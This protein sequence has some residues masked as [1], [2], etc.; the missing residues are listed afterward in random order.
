MKIENIELFKVP[1][2]WLFLKIT[3][4]EGIIGWG[5]P[6]VEGKADT[7]AA[8]VHEISQQLIGRPAAAIEDI[9]QTLYRGGFYRGGPILM[10]A[11][12]GID[13][14]LWDIKGKAL[15]VPV[16]ELLGGAVR[17]KMKMYCWIGGDTPE[18]IIE[19]AQSKVDQGFKAV[20]MNATGAFEWIDSTKKIKNVA[21]NIRL[22][23]E[24]FGDGLD[25]GLDFHGRVHKGMVKPLIDELATYRPMFI[26]EPVLAENNKALDHIYAYSPIPIAT[27]ERMFSR[28]DFKEILH[29]GVVD[30]IQPDLSH[31]GGI[32][33]VKRIASMAEAY[34][35]ALAPH[36]PLGPISLASALQIDFTSINACIQESS[37]GIH[38]NK[39]YDL[40]DYMENP[41]VFDLQDGYISLL[42]EP[43][44][45]VRIDEEKL[46]E[47]QKVGH[48][49]SNPIW[50]NQDGSL[51]EW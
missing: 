35:V 28:W 22:L 32:S 24:E 15:G 51:A 5:E 17:Q 3:T 7:V 13:Q 29:R 30:I 16:H 8:C 25:V 49:W 27:G 1:P 31:A 40:L 18:V 39:G 33:E 21:A 50:R 38:Y 46:R 19:Q 6:V 2:R 11:L 48:Q 9:W 47:A 20:K 14:A 23:R 42:K 10:S 12:A 4:G 44:L 41:E 43:G 26:E 36:C 45:G 37:L 34:D